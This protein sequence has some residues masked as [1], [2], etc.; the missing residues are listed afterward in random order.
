MAF[1]NALEKVWPE[2]AVPARLVTDNGAKFDNNTVVAYLKQMGIELVTLQRYGNFVERVIRTVR[3][4]ILRGASRP[5][6]TSSGPC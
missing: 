5:G 3:T 4:M 2:M 6:R 1:R